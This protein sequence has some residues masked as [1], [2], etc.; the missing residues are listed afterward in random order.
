MSGSRSSTTPDRNG[1]DGRRSQYVPL[2]TGDCPRQPASL[3]SNILWGEGGQDENRYR[4]GVVSASHFLAFLHL[5]CAMV[6]YRRAVTLN[7]LPNNPK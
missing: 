2:T 5:A 4:Q 1:D 6:C 7:L 3:P